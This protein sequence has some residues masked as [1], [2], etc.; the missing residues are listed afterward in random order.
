[1]FFNGTYRI[2]VA[3]VLWKS[4]TNQRGSSYPHFYC[5]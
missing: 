2:A 3:P 4:T 1:M 5:Y